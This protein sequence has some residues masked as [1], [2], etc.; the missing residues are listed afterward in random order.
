MKEIIRHGFVFG[1]RPGSRNGGAGSNYRMPILGELKQE[2]K[3]K[4]GN[5]NSIFRNESIERTNENLFVG[6]CPSY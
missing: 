1:I 2:R 3:K 5:G 6:P 4:E